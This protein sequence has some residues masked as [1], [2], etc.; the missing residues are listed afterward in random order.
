[1]VIFIAKKNKPMKKN[2]VILSLLLINAVAFSQEAATP[3]GAATKLRAGNYEDALTD[4]LF[5]LNTEPRNELYNYNAGVC[6][7]NTNENKAKAIP[8]LEIVTR[9]VVYN[10][11]ADYLLARAY[12][13]AGRNDDAVKMYDNY[14]AYLMQKGK[15]SAE[16]DEQIQYCLNAK[17]LMKYPVNVTFQSLGKNINSEYNDYYPFVTANES[18]LVFNSKRPEKN[19]E[20]LMNG[21]YG[22]SIFISKVA[23]G[24]YSKAT[25]I[26]APVNAGNSG[27]EVIGLSANGETMLLLIYNAAHKA[28]LYTSNLLAN[29]SYSKPEILLNNKINSKGD[30]IAAS[31]SVDGTVYFASNREGGYGGIDI[32]SCKVTPDGKWGVPQNLGPNINTKHDEDFPNIA[33]DGKVLYF[34]SKGRSSMGGYD[35]F[36]STYDENTHT[37]NNANNIGYPINTAYDDMNFRVSKNG[38]YGYIAAIRPNGYGEYDIYRVNFNEVENEYSVV[39]GGFKTKD[40]NHEINYADIFISVNDA[41]TKLLVGNYLPNPTN[42]R[43]I[44]ILNPGKYNVSIEASGMKTIEKTIEVLDKSSFQ[45]EIILDIE[46]TK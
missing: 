26:G 19:A 37:F 46:L 38:K 29:G 44:M 24:Q 36:K 42:G 20:R 34:S 11:E 18:F 14:K 4:Y 9:K 8:Y 16:V 22:N 10:H 35:I 5:L 27:T 28:T 6:Y 45:P 1:M 33:P 13:Y 7:L 21:E 3:D 17:E 12:Q 15:S 30:E 43:F 40:P 23:N 25:L 2:I 39:V 41:T 31:I 32:Y